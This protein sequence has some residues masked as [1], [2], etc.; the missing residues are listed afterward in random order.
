MVEYTLNQEEMFLQEQWSSVIP[1]DPPVVSFAMGSTQHLP[2]TGNLLAGYGFLLSQDDIR[3]K[4]WHTLAQS[5]VWTRVREYTHDSPSE[6]VWE[7]SLR[8][9]ENDF[10]LGWNLF[11]AK[12]LATLGGSEKDLKNIPRRKSF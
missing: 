12:R 11:S 8:A 6:V 5:R 4:T 3:D 7:L 10:G 2:K 9:R 1:D